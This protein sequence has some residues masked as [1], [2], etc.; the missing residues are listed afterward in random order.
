[1]ALADIIEMASDRGFE[2]IESLF[3]SR[4]GYMFPDNQEYPHGN[5]DEEVD[6]IRSTLISHGKYHIK[7]LQEKRDEWAII[8]A[9]PALRSTIS[10]ETNMTLEIQMSDL[11]LQ[12]T[13]KFYKDQGD[14]FHTSGIS[15]LYPN[16][17]VNDYSFDPC[18]YSLNALFDKYYYTI[19]VTPEAHCSYASFESTIP[20]KD[21]DPSQKYSFKEL[22]ME[23]IKIFKPRNFTISLVSRKRITQQLD[24]K[25]FCLKDYIFSSS[26]HD[27]EPADDA[28]GDNGW[29][30]CYYSF[31]I[32]ELDR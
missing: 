31:E 13:R 30:V 20:I 12:T 2:R 4:K 14:M 16:A 27:L 17:K 18:G 3:Y 25:G 23:N 29:C 22:I 15:R 1:L 19:H 26:H 10:E 28:M 32:E 7:N 8:I 24:L 11:D 5:W 6:Y 21:I 9:T